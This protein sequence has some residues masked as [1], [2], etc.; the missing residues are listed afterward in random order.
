MYRDRCCVSCP[1]RPF[2]QPFVWEE[3]V[4]LC[5]GSI[6]KGSTPNIVISSSNFSINQY[7]ITVK[8]ESIHTVDVFTTGGNDP[9]YEVNPGCS[10]TFD[11]SNIETLRISL[12][13]GAPPNAELLGTVHFAIHYTV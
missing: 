6:T 1:K 12:A 8:N 13:S 3:C 7:W 9:N 5:G 10:I 2:E 4:P 11:G